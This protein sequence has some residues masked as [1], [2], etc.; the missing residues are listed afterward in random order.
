MFF[1]ETPWLKEDWSSRDVLFELELGQPEDLGRNSLMQ[2]FK[3]AIV[4][5]PPHQLPR[6]AV[7]NQ[8]A[9]LAAGQQQFGILN[10]ILYH[11]GMVLLE[12]T[13][14]GTLASL[15]LREDETEEQIAWRVE[16]EV[17][18]RAG[19]R[20]ADIIFACL[21]C[22]F[23]QWQRKRPDLMDDDLCQAVMAHVITPLMEMTQ[24]YCD[25]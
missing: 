22:P 20:W 8:S 10:Q 9:S 3:R 21:H 12:L 18:G 16:R 6:N 15:R 24:L 1:H 2:P 4:P 7:P 14:D 17:C 11:L 25:D 19:P 23:G 13:M 5:V